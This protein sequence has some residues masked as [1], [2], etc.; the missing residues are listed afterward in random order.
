MTVHLEERI[1]SASARRVEPISS[2]EAGSQWKPASCPSYWPPGFAGGQYAGCRRSAGR[3]EGDYHVAV[4]GVVRRSSRD[5]D[6]AAGGTAGARASAAPAA[7]GGEVRCAF[8]GLPPVLTRKGAA[9][10]S[11]ADGSMRRCLTTSGASS[12]AR[13]LPS[14]RQSVRLPSSLAAPVPD[15]RRC[16]F[17]LPQSRLPTAPRSR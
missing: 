4:A 8:S 3:R 6:R 17:R 1:Q 12:I 7:Y 5:V 2:A 11:C 10:G 15:P 16:S 14:P 13:L 9:G